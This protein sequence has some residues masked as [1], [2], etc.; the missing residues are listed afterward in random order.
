MRTLVLG[1]CLACGCDAL[2][3]EQDQRDLIAKMQEVREHMHARF[4]ASRRVELAIAFGD[5]ERAREEARTIAN[6]EEPEARAEWQ[7]F[8]DSVRTAAKQIVVAPDT[9]VAARMSALLGQ[10]CAQC[11]VASHAKIAFADE[12]AP[13]GS[14]R[15]ATQMAQHQ[16]GAARMWEGLVGPSLERWTKGARSLAEA[17]IAIVAEGDLPPE[18]AVGDDV[19]RMHLYAKRA[20]SAKT[21]D[22]RAATYG[23][24]LATCAG[25]HRTIRD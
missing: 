3:V 2:T 19:Q 8:I 10:R 7:P 15:L 24:L 9:A 5:I 25:C 17:R 18:L 16:W 21:L 4:A 13:A 6:L 12:P 11:H 22:D 23:E 20:L 14:Q 1:I